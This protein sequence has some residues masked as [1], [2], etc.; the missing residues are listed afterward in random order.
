[1]QWYESVRVVRPWRKLAIQT[2][3]SYKCFY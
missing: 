3:K 2:D 1:M